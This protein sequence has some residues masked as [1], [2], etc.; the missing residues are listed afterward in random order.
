MR[1]VESR[2][3]SQGQR[4]DRNALA[5]IT[6]LVDKGAYDTAGVVAWDVQRNTPGDPAIWLLLTRIDYLR[7]RYAAAMYA[8]RMA[9]RLD[10]ASAHAWLWLARTGATRSRW[11]TEGLDAALQATALAPGDPQTWTAL[12]QLHLARDACYEAAIAAERAVRVGPDDA[13]AH[14]TL[15]LI[16]LRAEEWRHAVP[17]FRRVLELDADDA[18]ARTGL[19]EAFQALG[20]DPSDE[21][22]PYGPVVRRSPGLGNRLRRAARGSVTLTDSG[23]LPSQWRRLLIGVMACVTLGALLGLAAPGLGVVR[24][25]AGAGALALMWV[26]IWP[27][28]RRSRQAAPTSRAT[29]SPP[30][31]AATRD[32]R[33]ATPERPVAAERPAAPRPP[34]PRRPAAE[35]HAPPERAEPPPE[36]A[37]RAVAKPPPRPAEPPAS[38]QEAPQKA[39][40]ERPRRLKRPPQDQPQAPPDEPQA[41]EVPEAA[42]VKPETPQPSGDDPRHLEPSLT[43]AATRGTAQEN[44]AE[45]ATAAS[46][47]MP[48]DPAE[49]VAL[50][51]TRLAEFDLEAA[52]AAATRLAAVAPGSLEAHRALAAVSLAEQD[53]PQAEL[54]Y[55]KVLE[56]E[57]LDQEAIERLAMAKKGRRREQE[58]QRHRRRKG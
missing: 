51:Q 21:L 34:V 16:A 40:P 36:P 48:D 17:A 42:P 46:D 7:E 15:G 33:A 23:P 9:T 43:R 3:H 32:A 29:P 13:D 58:P 41:P 5:E 26:A 10:P 19:L 11:R 47:D 52:R 37:R 12:A 1:N 4:A 39:P 25:L 28:G 27:L 54:H 20:I 8:A 44:G 49:L 6:D 38:K 35:Q 45:P 53:Y 2:E 50:S 56:I 14:R 18:E 57:P 31:R 30:A 24:G 55:G 22:E